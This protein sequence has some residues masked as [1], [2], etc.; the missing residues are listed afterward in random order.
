MNA[1]TIGSHRLDLVALRAHVAD[2]AN[3]E[4]GGFRSMR[5]MAGRAVPVLERIVLLDI[6]D[7]HQDRLMALLA[8]LHAIRLE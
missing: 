5:G 1:A 7:R 3:H 2:P 8:Q 4:V 6:R